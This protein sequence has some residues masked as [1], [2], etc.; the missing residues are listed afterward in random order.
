MSDTDE[1]MDA[2]M[3]IRARHLF[4]EKQPDG[5]F[6]RVPQPYTRYRTLQEY[7]AELREEL[8]RP[9]GYESVRQEETK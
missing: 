5:S 4:V 6:K 1:L 9:R 3:R 8:D 7:S 2:M